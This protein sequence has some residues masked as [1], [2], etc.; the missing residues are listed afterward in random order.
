MVKIEFLTVV[1]FCVYTIRNQLLFE[2]M[3]QIGNALEYLH[4]NNV[5]YRDLKPDHI[6]LTETDGTYDCVLSGSDVLTQSAKPLSKPVG[7]TG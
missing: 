6:L 2:I 1:L 7:T 5:L 4:H 3:Y